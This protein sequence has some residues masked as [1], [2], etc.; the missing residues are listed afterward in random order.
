ML[1]L[2]YWLKGKGME[3]RSIA[4]RLR[5]TKTRLGLQMRAWN[6][7]RINEATSVTT[8]ARL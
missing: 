4:N 2:M 1:K 8:H 5:P 6:N 3:G 7:A